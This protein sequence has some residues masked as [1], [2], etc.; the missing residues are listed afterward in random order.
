MPKL[1]ESHPP[2]RQKMQKDTNAP[3]FASNRRQF[4]LHRMKNNLSDL[5]DLP[6]SP[7]AT[8]RCSNL[9][10]AFKRVRKPNEELLSTQ[11]VNVAGSSFKTITPGFVQKR[12]VSTLSNGGL[13]VHP[14][15]SDKYLASIQNDLQE[16]KPNQKNKKCP[17]KYQLA[18]MLINQFRT[19]GIPTKTNT[20][21]MNATQSYLQWKEREVTTE[22]IVNEGMMTGPTDFLKDELN[23]KSPFRYKKRLAIYRQNL[24]KKLYKAQNNSISSRDEMSF[25]RLKNNN[26]PYAV[27]RSSEN[28]IDTLIYQTT[29]T[30]HQAKQ[31]LSPQNTRSRQAAL[32]ST[33]YFSTNSAHKVTIKNTRKGKSLLPMKQCTIMTP[34]HKT[35]DSVNNT[36]KA[37]K[38][39][40]LRRDLYAT[41][42]KVKKQQNEQVTLQIGALQD[43]NS[44]HV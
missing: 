6:T 13:Q 34:S 27:S 20:T 18:D 8:W 19:T 40:K 24:L 26:D 11:L 42:Q 36:P 25:R 44:K 29:L 16:E 32:G 22:L 31:T 17:Q 1:A 35:L 15:Q 4:V 7:G 28:M 12:T 2:T 9:D 39:K 30:C 3:L 5:N 43:H 33:T 38:K 37:T 10:G 23:T 21:E 41:L 14:L